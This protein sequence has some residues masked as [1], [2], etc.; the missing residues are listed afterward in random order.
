VNLLENL[1]P[2]QLVA[3]GFAWEHP[4]VTW[5]PLPEG[6]IRVTVPA[7]ADYFR[8]PAGVIVSDNA[9]FLWKQVTGDFVAQAH[10]CPAFNSTYDSGVLMARHDEQNWAK[11]CFEKTDFGTTAAVSVVTRGTSDDAN[12]VD[13][14]TPDLWLQMIRAGNVFA[15][16]YSLDGQSWRMVRIFKLEVPASIR[17]GVVTQCPVGPGTTVDLLSLTI[18]QRPVK[19]V[20]AGV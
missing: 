16:H 5:E 8:D 10:V 11:L 3:R 2:D 12:G 14:T 7:K 13:V 9:P 18:D 4:P 6:G 19:N 1:T 17:V 20:R 15:L